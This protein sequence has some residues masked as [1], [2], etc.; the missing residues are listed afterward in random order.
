MKA[1]E[2]ALLNGVNRS[3]VGRF[4]GSLAAGISSLLVFGLLH[5][6][7]LAGR[8]GVPANLI[9][10]VLSLVIAALV[11]VGLYWLF[12]RHALRFSWVRGILDVPNL[13]GEWRCAGKTVSLDGSPP[14]EWKGSVTIVQTWDK[15]RV[16]LKTE[17]SGSN[18]IAAA[19]A[20]DEVDGFRLLYNYINEPRADQP[21]LSVHRGWADIVFSKDLL[22]GQGEYFNGRGRITYGTMELTR[23]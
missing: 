19:L 4:L 17:Q 23:I 5:F 21:Q 10:S 3:N 9:P 7:D 1:H 2:Y 13:A 11:F 16:R 12:N 18:S 22:T 15:I 8:L 6:V 14:Y 20:Y